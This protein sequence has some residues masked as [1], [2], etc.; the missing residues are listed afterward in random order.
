MT[1]TW[2]ATNTVRTKWTSMPS[3][4]GRG[5]RARAMHK[6]QESPV[7]AQDSTRESQ[8]HR[9]IKITS[10]ANRHYNKIRLKWAPNPNQGT[11]PSSQSRARTLSQQKIGPRWSQAL[12]KR[13]TT[14]IRAATTRRWLLGTARARRTFIS[15]NSKMEL[16][17]MARARSNNQNSRGNQ[18]ILKWPL[19]WAQRACQSALTRSTS[20]LTALSTTRISLW[21]K[22][23]LNHL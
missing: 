2:T 5:D 21:L 19:T 14:R 17:S 22:R 3:P 15:N 11:Q 13:T 16:G 23:I 12:G 4:L 1:T 18:S 6:I 20:S 9:I 10:A 8:L 7:A